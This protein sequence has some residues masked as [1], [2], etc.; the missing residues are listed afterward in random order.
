[1]ATKSRRHVHKYYRA[2]VAGIKV[3]ACGL[4]ECTHYMPSHMETL[5]NGKASICWN[6]DERMILNPSNMADDKPIC[7]DCTATKEIAQFRNLAV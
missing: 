1:M 4:P 3:W 2:L 5:V 7:D 6:C